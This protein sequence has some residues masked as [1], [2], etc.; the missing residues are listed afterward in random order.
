MPRCALLFVDIEEKEGPTKF[1][2]PHEKWIKKGGIQK[3]EMERN[4]YESDADGD[5]MGD[6]RME[7]TTQPCGLRTMLPP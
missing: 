6:S 1:I 4:V 2:H 5:M 7:F 3:S